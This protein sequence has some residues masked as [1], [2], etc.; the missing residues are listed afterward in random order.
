MQC[1][2]SCCTL[3]Y[4]VVSFTKVYSYV[5]KKCLKCCQI[6]VW[7][8]YLIH[9]VSIYSFFPLISAFYEEEVKNLKETKAEKLAQIEKEIEMQKKFDSNFGKNWSDFSKR[10]LREEHHKYKHNNDGFRSPGASFDNRGHMN[11]FIHRDHD[12]DHVTHM[13]MSVTRPIH[14]SKQNAQTLPTWPTKPGRR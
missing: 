7:Y 4:R 2:Y 6:F 11:N 3:I 12:H 13:I 10:F 8:Q 14:R 1:V 9:K 5:T